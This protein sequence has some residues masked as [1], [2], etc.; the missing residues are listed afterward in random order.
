VAPI[1]DDAGP[2]VIANW[3]GA[4]DEF[5]QATEQQQLVLSVSDPGPEVLRLYTDTEEDVG[6]A[7]ILA[8]QLLG[9]VRRPASGRRS[10]RH[11]LVDPSRSISIEIRSTSR[12]ATP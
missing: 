11:P 4:P 2:Y 3:K 9:V 6:Q 10:C 8:D 7:P 5:N 12:F 1:A